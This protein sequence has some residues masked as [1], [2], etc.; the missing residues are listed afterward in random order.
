MIRSTIS[1][2]SWRWCVPGWHDKIVR[3]GSRKASTDSAVGSRRN[4]RVDVVAQTCRFC[5]WWKGNQ[6]NEQ[7][8][9][10]KTNRYSGYPIFFW[11]TNNFNNLTS[12]MSS[13]NRWGL[14]FR[15]PSFRKGNL[16]LTCEGDF[17]C[18]ER[19]LNEAWNSGS[20]QFYPLSSWTWRVIWLIVPS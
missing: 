17:F 10:T 11:E 12:R 8:E 19:I 13:K 1:P 7:N 5:W 6:F 3:V 18:A 4:G 15:I 14:S 2:W 16:Q 20:L 9:W